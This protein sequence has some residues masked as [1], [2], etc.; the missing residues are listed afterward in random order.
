MADDEVIMM[1]DDM[2]NNDD[3]CCQAERQLGDE[4]SQLKAD[5][6]SSTTE[7]DQLHTDK[8]LMMICRLYL[9]HTGLHSSVYG[10]LMDLCGSV[11]VRK[12]RRGR[13]IDAH[14]S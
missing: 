2:F 8:V 13:E 14:A 1:M 10:P 4:V 3:V 12:G 7:R 11:G 6:Q 9:P 5:V